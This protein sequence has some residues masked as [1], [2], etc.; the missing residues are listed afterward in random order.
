MPRT[1]WSIPN[2]SRD[3]SSTGAGIVGRENVVGGRRFVASGGRVHAEIGWT[4]LAA[5]CPKGR[6]LATENLVALTGNRFCKRHGFP[7]LAA[8]REG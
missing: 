6:L 3:A 2:S 5:A 4:K 8:V 1:S 7:P